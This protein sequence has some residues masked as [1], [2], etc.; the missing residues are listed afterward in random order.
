M[1]PEGFGSIALRSDDQGVCVP[2][3][4]CFFPD[5][6]IEHADPKQLYQKYGLDSEGL[7]QRVIKRLNAKAKS[8][9]M[10]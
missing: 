2:M 9:E 10:K 3:N 4:C 5:S 7:A 8:E 6:P 1:P